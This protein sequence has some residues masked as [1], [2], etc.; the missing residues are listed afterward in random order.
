MMVLKENALPGEFVK[1]RCV[2]TGDEVGPHSVPDDYDNVFGFAAGNSGGSQKNAE[3]NRND[4]A[5][6]R[7]S[8]Q[9]SKPRVKPKA[10]ER[11]SGVRGAHLDSTTISSGSRVGTSDHSRGLLPGH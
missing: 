4:E 5:H 9:T 7:M 8:F 2:L 1:C 3:K 11:C 10:P 6:V